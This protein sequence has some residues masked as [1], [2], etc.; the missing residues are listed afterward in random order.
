MTAF[1]AL[2]LVG[3]GR[4]CFL[5]TAL[6]V[7][8]AGFAGE[9]HAADFKGHTITIA[10]GSGTGGGYDAYGRLAGRHLGKH[11]PGNPAVVPKNMPGAGGVVAANW[12]YNVA[13]KDGTALGIF[14]AGTAF[15]P[16]FGNT[17]TKFDPLKF[18]WLISLNRISNIGVFW[19]E[20]PIKTIDDLFQGEVLV[21]STAGGNS[22]TQVFPNLLNNLIGTK[23][24]VIL[25][26]TGTGETT[27]AMERGEVYGIVGTDWSSLKASK[28]DWLRDKKARVV[29]QI[30]LA[31][32][33]ELKDVPVIVDR[34]QDPESR[35]VMELLLARQEYGRSYAAP[36]DIPADVAAALR[37]GFIEMAKDPA[38]LSEA[39]KMGA[40]IEVGTHDQ[41]MALLDKTF[42]APKPLV[43][44]AIHEFKRAGGQ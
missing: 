8:V 38:M 18:T 16:L 17:Q 33:P 1:S 37:Q 36:P 9:S 20:S 30:A 43:E 2:R 13:P 35:Q 27:I 25:G 26:Y 32:H 11:L 3:R 12:V 34:I 23:F 39:D 29:L 28:P 19:H 14:Q 4:T 10:I 21:G 31:S 40:E 6:C 44:H 15:E 24:K 5:A 7:V 42:G 22:S 41:I